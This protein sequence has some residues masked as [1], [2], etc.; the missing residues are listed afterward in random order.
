[1]DGYAPAYVAHNVPLLIVSGLGPAHARQDEEGIRVVSEVHTVESD[2]A[3][4]L[5]RHLI[6]SDAGGLAWN[7]REYNGRNR[8][9]VKVVGRVMPRR[10]YF[11]QI[12]PTNS[13][14]GIRLAKS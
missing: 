1:M 12:S 14:I 7:G 9:R 6:D 5:L 11:L 13:M 8:F 3:Q 2:D 10:Q 4:I